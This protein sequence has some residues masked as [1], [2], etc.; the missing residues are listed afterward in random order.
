[1]ICSKGVL[2]ALEGDMREYR[3]AMK[4]VK[5]ENGFTARMFED[6]PIVVDR[7]CPAGTLYLLNTDDF[8]LHQLCD[9]QWMESEDGKVLKQVPGKPIYTATLVKYAELMCE[10]P[11]AQGMIYNIAE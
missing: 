4:V 7:F 6:I 3:E 11:F 2:R 9:W 5:T 1:M 8:K 10:R